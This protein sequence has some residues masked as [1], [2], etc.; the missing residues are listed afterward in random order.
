M[1]PSNVED[2]S[3]LNKFMLYLFCHHNPL[4]DVVTSPLVSH[5]EVAGQFPAR[6][7]FTQ[8]SLVGLCGVRARLAT[9][10]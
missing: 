4:R 9:T 10:I 7:N 1:I 3:A 5:E 2:V 6:S 8:L